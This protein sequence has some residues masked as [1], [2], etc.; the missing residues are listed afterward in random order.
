MSSSKWRLVPV[1]YDG[2]TMMKT[3]PVDARR[4]GQIGQQ[5][6]ERLRP[7]L[8]PRYP[9][10]IVAIDVGS[11]DYFVGDTLHEAIQKGRKKYPKKVFYIVKVGSPAVFSFPSRA[12]ISATTTTTKL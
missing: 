12:P 2:F 6:Y 11:K 8:E 5:I 3:A 7:K 10:K 4:I 1:W 9:G